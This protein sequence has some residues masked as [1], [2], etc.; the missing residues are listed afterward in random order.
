MGR[1]PRAGGRRRDGT[2]EPGDQLSL[3]QGPRPVSYLPLEAQGLRQ[4]AASWSARGLDLQIGV[5][6]QGWGH[7]G[8]CCRLQGAV[9]WT[10]PCHSRPPSALCWNALECTLGLLLA[11]PQRQQWWLL[12]KPAP[13][14]LGAMESASVWPFWDMNWSSLSVSGHVMVGKAERTKAQGRGEKPSTHSRGVQTPPLGTELQWGRGRR[15]MGTEAPGLPAA[16]Q[17][18]PLNA[19]WA[20]CLEMQQGRWTGGALPMGGRPGGRGRHQLK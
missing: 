2:R 7:P 13:I 4:R 16:C 9:V 17:G 20:R 3:A 12:S 1:R 6:P 19:H 5:V 8:P 10:A 14:T 18:R 15:Y 11:T